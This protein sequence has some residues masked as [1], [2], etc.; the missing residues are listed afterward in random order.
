MQFTKE[1][2]TRLILCG[3][4]M[5]M[6]VEQ[7]ANNST[8]FDN[9]LDVLRKLHQI[10]EEWFILISPYFEKIG[11]RDKTPNILTLLVSGVELKGMLKKTNEL[12][13]SP[14]NREVIGALLQGKPV[15]AISAPVSNSTKLKTG[16]QQPMNINNFFSRGNDEAYAGVV[17]TIH[18]VR[19]IVEFSDT[20]KMEWQP[21]HDQATL[22]QMRAEFD[23]KIHALTAREN[24]QP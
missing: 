20:T 13:F 15:C 10:N 11:G 16:G 1:E 18:T 22:D 3:A 9:V 5:L 7:L 17:E 4:K 14:H 19:Y 8:N 6:V 2:R 24:F 21:T 12:V 23:Q